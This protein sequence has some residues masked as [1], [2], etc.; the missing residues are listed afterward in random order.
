MS[1]Y[2]KE[3]TTNSYIQ[4][5]G[6]QYS[7][8]SNPDKKYL[9][10][11]VDKA[12][13]IVLNHSIVDKFLSKRV[14]SIYH[15]ETG[16]LVYD[17]LVSDIANKGLIHLNISKAVLNMQESLSEAPVTSGIPIEM[18]FKDSISP[19][20]SHS[21]C[22]KVMIDGDDLPIKDLTKRY[23]A[24]E[25]SRNKILPP[26]EAMS[27]TFENITSAINSLPS[28]EDLATQ[29]GDYNAQVVDILHYIEF[30]HL[31]ACNGYLIFK[32]LQDTLIARRTVKEQIEIIN[33]LENCGLIVE[34]INAANNQAKKTLEESRSYCPRTDIDIFD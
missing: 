13:N 6:N 11:D 29:L 8:I 30:S 3:T 17:K 4:F 2:L 9:F 12:V 33:K 21:A 22:A 5:V 25:Y 32:K 1:F 24:S 7:Y 28:N 10:K 20:V 16:N 19:T 26:L 34:K 31:D 23:Q 27:K 15:A 18:E 14:F